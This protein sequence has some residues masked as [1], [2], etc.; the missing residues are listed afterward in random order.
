M[1]HK[2]QPDLAACEIKSKKTKTLEYLTLQF[3]RLRIMGKSSS[4]CVDDLSC[5]HRKFIP[6]L[7][8]TYSMVVLTPRN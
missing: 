8:T 2:T 5:L 6:L 3:T 7:V 1:A 4:V